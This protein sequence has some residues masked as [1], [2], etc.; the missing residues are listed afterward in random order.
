MN[1]C[2][3]NED[4]PDVMCQKSNKSLSKQGLGS[5]VLSPS[6]LESGHAFPFSPQDSCSPCEFVH[7]C[8]NTRL[9]LAGIHIRR[10]TSM[11]GCLLSAPPLGT[12][13]PTQACI[14]T[15]NRTSDPLV[16]WTALSPLSHT[17]QGKT[18]F[19]KKTM[20]NSQ[21]CLSLIHI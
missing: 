3:V 5:L 9:L 13:P 7:C 14:L 18:V 21:L 17:S 11:C 16:R 12:W 10:A 8:H 15:G 4:H 20:K 6:Y 19:K 2:I 1:L